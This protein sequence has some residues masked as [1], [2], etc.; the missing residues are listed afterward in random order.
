[1]SKIGAIEPNGIHMSKSLGRGSVSLCEGMLL[2][3]SATRFCEC[4]L[5]LSWADDCYFPAQEGGESG[6]KALTGSWTK[7]LAASL[8]GILG[9]CYLPLSPIW[10]FR[11]GGS[12]KQDLLGFLDPRA[13]QGDQSPSRRPIP[14]AVEKDGVWLVPGK[15]GKEPKHWLQRSVQA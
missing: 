8:L 4:S 5:H 13:G 3:D 11:F 10:L 15:F 14:S 7:G 1:M 9:A 2:I 12:Q 6:A